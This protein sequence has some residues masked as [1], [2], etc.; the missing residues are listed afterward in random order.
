MESASQI[1]AVSRETNCAKLLHT[2]NI[3][4]PSTFGQGN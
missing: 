4:L 1:Y 2:W 3:E